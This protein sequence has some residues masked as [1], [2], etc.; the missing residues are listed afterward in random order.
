M[1]CINHSGKVAVYYC[2]NCGKPLCLGCTVSGAM[3]HG[4]SGRVLCQECATAWR[5][6]YYQTPAQPFA[7]PS[8]PFASPFAP[9]RPSGPSP[10]AAAGLG[11]IPGVGAMYNGQFLKGFIHVIIFAA[12]LSITMHYWIFCF[13]LAA[14]VVYQS[15]EAYHTAMALRAGQP[16]PDPFG[17]NEIGGWLNLGGQPPFNPMGP[18]AAGASE[19]A[20]ESAAPEAEGQPQNPNP[21]PGHP[22]QPVE[23]LPTHYWRRKEP[24]GAIVLIALG[25]LFL[26]GQ[27]DVFHGRF[28]AF[29]WP[30]MLI[31][32]GVWLIVRRIGDSQGGS[33]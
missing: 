23:F 13:I 29:V 17:L 14:W 31:A 20:A 10:S 19:A 21:P 22:W 5:Q 11:V 24:I 1:D 6:Q 30:L 18:S 12:L 25:T 33:K 8:A 9:A 4:S 32:L 3:G 28:V 16:P 26:L 15:F 27:L 7:Q 2:Q